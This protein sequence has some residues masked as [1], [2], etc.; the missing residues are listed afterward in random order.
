MLGI[1]CLGHEGIQTTLETYKYLYKSANKE[2]AKNLITIIEMSTGNAR[3]ELTSNQHVKY[4]DL[5]TKIQPL[6]IQK[7]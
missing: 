4:D 6:E 3:W 1:S 2:I 5:N 7:F